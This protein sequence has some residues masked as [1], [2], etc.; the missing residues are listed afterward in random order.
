[1]PNIFEADQTSLQ[2][3]GI[4]GMHWGV[5]RFQKDD[6]TLTEAGKKRY[7]QVQE[8][9]AEYKKAK[10]DVMYYRNY[11][12]YDAESENRFNK[13]SG[14]YDLRKKQL[15]DE[16]AKQK[17]AGRTKIGK[18]EQALIEKYKE[19][20]MSDEEA[21]VAA[22]KRAKLE[23][24][25][26]AAGAV[27]VAVATAYGAKKYHD[28]VSDEI[29]EVGKVSMKRVAQSDSADVHDTFYAAFNKGDV[30]KYVGMYG[31]QIKNAGAKNVYQK[32]IDLK[33]NI[34]I[35][36][37]K[38]AKQT[39]AEVLSKA[40]Q[41]DKDQ[42]INTLEQNRAAFLLGGGLKQGATISKAISDIKAGKYNTKA[43]YDSM[44]MTFGDKGNTK[45]INDFKSAIK[46]AGYAGVK[47]RNDAKYSG[48][49]ASSARIIFD[50]S[51]VKVSD[52]RKVS[53][54]EIESANFKELM[55]ISAKQIAKVSGIAAGASMAYN[56]A[57]RSKE[58]NKAIAD[59][60]KEHPNTKLSNDEILENYY[61]GDKK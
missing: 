46:A 43:V 36:S 57:A 47:D 24:T 3:H 30:N 44:N 54:S 52:V 11:G 22:Y 19:K 59:Y 10:K 4:K 8:A 53:D 49:N 21:A 58:N 5:R 39:M 6:G 26:I 60:K 35:A 41:K 31:T 23:K 15:S 28:Y 33:E 45:V 7:N 56:K 42:A 55:K 13:A 2:H 40:S 1:M 29:L 48:Y 38:K 37:D 17:M 34:K 14:M 51:K 9:K 16:K 25:L 18:R 32:S 12:W 61:G 20:G 27:T 50:N